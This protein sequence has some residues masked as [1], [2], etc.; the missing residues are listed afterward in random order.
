MHPTILSRQCGA[1]GSGDE[2]EW[3][4]GGS[5]LEVEL[6]E[7]ELVNHDLTPWTSHHAICHPGRTL[8]RSPRAL[9]PPKSDELPAVISHMPATCSS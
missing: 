5:R 3:G 1:V 6:V 4:S 7:V 8:R 9:D 2:C